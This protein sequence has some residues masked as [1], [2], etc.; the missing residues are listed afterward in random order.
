MMKTKRRYFI[1]MALGVVMNEA[2]Y[3][4]C[5]YF[6]L[7][8]WLD[9]SGTVFAAVVLEPTAG[10]IVGLI[11][12]FYLAITSGNNQDMLFYAVSAAVAVITGVGLRRNGRIVWRRLPMVMGL[13][14]LSNCIIVNILMLWVNKGVLGS[15]WAMIFYNQAIAWGWPE[16]LSSIFG[17]CIVKIMD[18]IA[19]CL[20]LPVFFYCLPKGLKSP[21]DI[22]D[23]TLSSEKS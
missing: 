19:T 3:A 16:V 6:Q 11:N 23:S 5:H 20:L 2:L 1:V 4:F 7:P 21:I 15:H 13:M 12:N 9:T 18:S 14:I 17:T 10:L 8:L 22:S